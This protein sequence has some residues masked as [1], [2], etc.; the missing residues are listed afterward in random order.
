M[1]GYSRPGVFTEEILNPIA[2]TAGANTTA[3]AVLAGAS[4]RGPITPTLVSNWAQYTAAFG[5]WNTVQSNLLPLAAYQ[6]FANGGRDLLVVRVPAAGAVTATRSVLDRKVSSPPTT[7]T[8]SAKSPGATGNLISF[9]I[10]DGFL[11]DTP[12]VVT[13]FDLTV[14]YGGGSNAQVV[15]TFTDLSMSPSS[16]RYFLPIINGTS[17]YV[18]VTDAASTTTAPLNLPALSSNVSLATGADGGVPAN[19]LIVSTVTSLLTDYFRP[20]VINVPGITA[21]ADV[22]PL[23]AWAEARADAFVVVDGI[24]DVSTSGVANQQALVATYTNSSYAAVYYPAPV[25]RDPVH[26]EIPGATVQV[27]PGGSILGQIVATD[28]SR[29][30]FKAPAGY[31]NNIAGA[32][33]VKLLSPTELNN[34]NA[35]TS[36]AGSPSSCPPIN[37]IRYVP[38]NGICVMGARTLK[39][40]YADRYINVRRTLIELRKTLTQMTSFAVF[41]NNDDRLWDRLTQTCSSY[42]FNLWQSGGLAGKTTGDSYFVKCDSSLNTVSVR[43][44]GEVRIEV[45]VALQRPAEFVVIKIGQFDGGSTATTSV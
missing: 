22:N 7:M 38:G 4:D 30:V 21:A 11:T 9:D 24:L 29:G 19:A 10:T 42:L 41:E 17:Q 8:I 32:V 40:G 39:P 12:G 31:Q 16:S 3:L 20:I 25:I 6:F 28:V 45:G 26:S 2:T 5:Q 35:G 23:I 27:Y 33:S 14:R 1:P 36:P 44:S 43:N 18:V 34:L 37:A 15:E 13:R